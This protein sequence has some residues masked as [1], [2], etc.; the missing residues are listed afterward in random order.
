MSTPVPLAD[1]VARVV[2]QAPTLTPAQRQRLADILGGG[3]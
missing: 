2:A 1:A 3:R